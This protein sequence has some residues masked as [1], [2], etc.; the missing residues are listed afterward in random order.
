MGIQWR[1][2]RGCEKRASARKKKQWRRRRSDELVKKV[3]GFSLNK[4][5]A[6]RNMGCD[7]ECKE[8]A[9]S[10]LT[11]GKFRK[12]PRCPCATISAPSNHCRKIII[13]MTSYFK[14]AQV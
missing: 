14:F 13:S 12:L 11:G 5:S 2:A 9:A 10:P 8:E 6:G 4:A 1:G 7:M 3:K